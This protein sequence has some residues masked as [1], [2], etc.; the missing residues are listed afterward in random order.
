MRLIRLV[1][2]VP[3]NGATMKSEFENHFNDNIIIKANAKV[4]LLSASL[5]ILSSSITIDDTCNTFQYKCAAN[6]VVFNNIVIPNREYDVDSLLSLMT[7]MIW[8]TL[9][10]TNNADTGTYIKFIL[11][12]DKKVSL[13]VNRCIQESMNPDG[14]I[15]INTGVTIGAGAYNPLTRT[16]AAADNT[17]YLYSKVPILPSCSFVRTRIIVLAPMILGLCQPD[18]DPTT[19]TLDDNAFSHA[20]KIEDNGAGVMIYKTLN[21]NRTWTDGAPALFEDYFT[22]EVTLGY[23][24]YRYYRGAGPAPFNLAAL[25]GFTQLENHN[26]AIGLRGATSSCRLPTCIYDPRIVVNSTG[27]LVIRNEEEIETLLS[28]QSNFSETPLGALPRVP[29]NPAIV[30][31]T[32]DFVQPIL[33]IKLGFDKHVLTFAG[34]QARFDAMLVYNSDVLP[35]SISIQIP[36]FRL[37]SYDGES[38]TRKNILSILTSQVENASRG[39]GRAIYNISNPIMLSIDSANDM[40]LRMIRA[41]IRSGEDDALL[42]VYDKIEL[43]ILIDD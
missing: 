33:M 43:V 40:N 7:T 17:S 15:T 9:S 10:I 19:G 31:F 26:F 39:I 2:T 4:G 36:N 1:S 14:S 5:P 24:R 42:N 28:R 22:I 18:Y 32:F 6:Q 20:I 29:T 12:R 37:N 34:A 13:I 25:R 30:V 27:D 21:L 16:V 23:I 8:S 38:R 3:V 41:E 35:S 11:K